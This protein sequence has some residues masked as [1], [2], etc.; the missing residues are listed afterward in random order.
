M[1][2]FSEKDISE[3]ASDDHVASTEDVEFEP[4][5]AEP[6]D[7]ARVGEQVATV[8]QS[9]HSAADEMRAAAHH[10]AERIGAEAEAAA[11]RMIADSRREAEAMR[12]ELQQLRKDAEI[13]GKA[14]R[15]DADAYSVEA[16]HTAD[17]EA[18]RKSTE[19]DD[20]LRAARAEAKRMVKEATSEGQRRKEALAAEAARF[21]ARLANFLTLFRGVTVQLEDVLTMASTVDSQPED[22]AQASQ[23]GSLVEALKPKPAE[24]PSKSDRDLAERRSRRAST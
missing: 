12:R 10:D 18:G 14:V 20:L 16:R 15:E 24:A 22:A 19:A 21:E 4:Y 8:L 6:L 17:A 9:A 1:A 7:L 13:Y 23:E 11:E 5:A 3:E 2:T